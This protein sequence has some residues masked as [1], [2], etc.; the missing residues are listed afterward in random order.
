[1]LDSRCLLRPSYGF[2]F[3]SAILWWFLSLAGCQMAACHLAQAQVL[4]EKSKRPNILWITCEDTGPHLG[5]YGDQ[6]A[7]TPRIDQFA[8]RALRFNRCWS[9]APVCA[10]ARTTLIAGIYPTSYGAQPMRSSV[11]LPEGFKTLPERLRDAG[12]YC[13]NNNK[14]DYNFYLPGSDTKESSISERM[15]NDS[16]KKAHWKNRKDG[17]S[18]FSV[19]N[20]T[21]THEGQI[22]K[23][24]YQPKHDPALAPIPPY[25]PD[26]PEVRLDWAQY[27]DRITEMDAMVGQVLDELRSDGLDDS[28]IVFFFGDHGCGLPR[29]KRWLYESGLR[30]PMLVHIPPKF[31]GRYTKEVDADGRHSGEYREGAQSDRLVS[32]VDLAPTVL[33]MCGIEAS[34]DRHEA[35]HGRSF[36]VP[37]AQVNEF[38]IGFRDRMDERMDCSRAIRNERYMYIRNFVPDRPQGAYLNYMFQTPTTREWF[39]LFQTGEL[40]AK[41]SAFW[42]P[43]PVEEFYDIQADPHQVENLAGTTDV[44]LQRIREELASRLKSHMLDVGDSGAIPEGWLTHRQPPDRS[45]AIEAAWKSGS[46]LIALEGGLE[47]EAQLGVQKEALEQL[48]LMLQSDQAIQRYWG[49]VA[50]RRLVQLGQ[51]VPLR[52]S[53]LNL[54]NDPVLEIRSVVA[55]AVFLMEPSG[56]RAGRAVEVLVEIVEQ[57]EASWGARILALNALCDIVAERDIAERQIAE[58]DI[59]ASRSMVSRVQSVFEKDGSKWKRGLPSRYHEYAERLVQRLVS[60]APLQ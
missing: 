38:V 17:E 39:R 56:E 31:A 60:I 28:T 42:R 36:F 47:D 19:F 30:V 41:Q 43:K 4:G 2:G 12:Y 44:R 46:E 51:A 55:E 35:L 1:M 27:Y 50:V 53:L 10:P 21:V 49:G 25:H 14:E 7:Q 8:R 33:E 13:S 24:P 18:F 6:Y 32:F 40:S 52:E 16:S 48:K 34:A 58:R 11:P 54:L 5:C 59:G 26:T 37:Q 22:R 29:G 23:R 57:P 15:W 20:F 3:A 9:N 45:V